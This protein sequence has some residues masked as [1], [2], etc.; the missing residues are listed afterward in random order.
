[1][2]EKDKTPVP[3]IKIPNK[4]TLSANVREWFNN[5]RMLKPKEVIVTVILL[6]LI[7]QGVIFGVNGPYGKQQKS[8]KTQNTY[9]SETNKKGEVTIIQTIGE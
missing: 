9:S 4:E 2:K 7:I 8:E 5:L 3:S 6:L 1:M